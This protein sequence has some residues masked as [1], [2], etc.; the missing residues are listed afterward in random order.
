MS[1]AE[2]KKINDNMSMP[3]DKM[4]MTIFSGG[5]RQYIYETQNYTIPFDGEYTIRAY[6]G[7]YGSYGKLVCKCKKGEILSITMNTN[8]SITITS[9]LRDTNTF[10]INLAKDSYV[11]GNSANSIKGIAIGGAEINADGGNAYIRCNNGIAA[12]G[13]GS[14]GA[15]NAGGYNGGAAYSYGT[16]VYSLGGGGGGGGKPSVSGAAP[17]GYRRFSLC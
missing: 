1:W 3:L 2:V 6:C 13:G 8:N 10:H 7:A 14:G 15:T 5:L 16:N 12:G 4:L 11:N 17:Q 9:N